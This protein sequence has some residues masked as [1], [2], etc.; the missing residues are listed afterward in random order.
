[1]TGPVG[2]EGNGG[3]TPGEGG[4]Q[5]TLF[6]QDQVNAFNAA[7][8][9]GAVSNFFKEL[10]FDSVPDA[11]AVKAA[12]DDAG[13]L[14]KLK[15]G[16]KGD[17]ERLNTE[18]SAAQK[19]AGE[20]PELKAT[21]ERQRIAADEGLP[22]RFWKYVEGKTED[23]I[24]E[25][26]TGLKTELGITTESG[27]QQQQGTPTGTGARPPLPNPQQGSSGGGSGPG[28]TL[29]AGREAYEAKHGKKA[30]KE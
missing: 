12:F 20:V 7:T 3:A 11:E 13:A 4:V 29:S 14:K 23:E 1:M 10:G 19:T 27:G 25:S 26:I 17:V 18:L 5:A 28:K 2:S 15:D 9:R 21:I 30:T 6:T 24:K 22:S 16:E 8:K